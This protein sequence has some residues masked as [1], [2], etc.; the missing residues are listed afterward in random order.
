[1]LCRRCVDLV[2]RGGGYLARQPSG[3]AAA[4]G[5]LEAVLCAGC[6][7]V[8]PLD[9]STEQLLRKLSQLAGFGLTSTPLFKP[10][11]RAFEDG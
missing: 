2:R 11:P 9:D 5:A 3:F 10:L 6:G 4:G 8:L 7:T 1:M